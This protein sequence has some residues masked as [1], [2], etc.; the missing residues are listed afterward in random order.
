MRALSYLNGHSSLTQSLWVTLP[1]GHLAQV[2]ILV[3]HL[4]IST[5]LGLPAG[6]SLPVSLVALWAGACFSGLKKY[7]G[8]WVLFLIVWFSFF[9]FGVLLD[10]LAAE[11][12]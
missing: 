4:V 3:T 8:F 7:R 10:V 9:L 5:V 6:V 11:C 2:V 1:G 12:K